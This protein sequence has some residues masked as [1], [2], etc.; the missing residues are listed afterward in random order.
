MQLR[1]IKCIFHLY[2]VYGFTFHM[3]GCIRASL[4]A[5]MIKNPPA[6]QEAWVQSLYQEDPL[7]KGTATHS[8]I[9]AWRTL[10]TEEPVDYSTWVRKESDTTE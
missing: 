3:C 10:W 9:L 1:R 8:S 2:H 4:V 5:Q 7:G 6:R